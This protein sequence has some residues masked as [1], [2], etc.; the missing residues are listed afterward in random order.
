METITLNHR[1]YMESIGHIADNATHRFALQAE[2]WW[3]RHFSW[4]KDGCRVLTDEKGEH[5]AYLFY[6]V[7]RYRDYL[8]IHNLFTPQC[9]RENGY[10]YNMLETL[11]LQQADEGVLRFK[12]NCTPQAL[13]FYKKMSLIYWGV[14]EIGNYHCDL[15]LPQDGIAGIYTMIRT[16]SDAALLGKRAESIYEK[17]KENGSAF[18]ETAVKNFESD[19]KR[20]GN[21][22]RHET[23]KKLFDM[24]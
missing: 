24:C 20:L 23:L 1:Q 22:Y 21:A 18:D 17:V 7:D 8:T 5:L 12:M 19:K 6:K 3:N 14:D 13:D 4:N 16:E 11:F 9:H 2:N 10:A 15:P